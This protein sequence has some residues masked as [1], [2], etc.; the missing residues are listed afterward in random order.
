LG[1]S[2]GG[3]GR[4]NSEELETL[5]SLIDTFAKRTKVP[6]TTLLTSDLGV[7]LPLHISLSRSLQVPTEGRE[8]LLSAVTETISKAGVN[9]FTVTSRGLKWVS[10]YDGTRWFLALVL[11]RV[12][13]DGLNRLLVACNQV[14]GGKGYPTLYTKQRDAQNRDEE[15]YSNCF[16]FSLAWSLASN[17]DAKS[18]DVV[19]EDIWKGSVA[20]GLEV[21]VDTVLVKIGNA[22][23]SIKLDSRTKASSQQNAFK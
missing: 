3:L 22:V 14:A 4:P 13:N 15:D 16:H 2:S 7:T 19:L 21:L 5:Q 6:V 1:R 9:S 17:I 20:H 23:H 12:D 18:S 11:N 8:E 10:N